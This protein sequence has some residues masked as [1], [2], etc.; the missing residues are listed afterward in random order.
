M[1]GSVAELGDGVES[2][3]VQAGEEVADLGR[4]TLQE[5]QEVYNGGLDEI[6]CMRAKGIL[7][8]TDV[9]KQFLALPMFLDRTKGEEIGTAISV[10]HV[11]EAG[12]FEAASCPINGSQRCQAVEGD[13]SGSNTDYRSMLLV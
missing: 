12:P 1:V 7:I 6:L 4:L 11:I 8:G 5:P 9:S 3:V 13:H 2:E 10:E